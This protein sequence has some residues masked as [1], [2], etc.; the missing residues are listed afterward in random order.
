[1]Q[2]YFYLLCDSEKNRVVLLQ[3]LLITLVSNLLYI[4]KTGELGKRHV[5][6]LI[7]MHCNP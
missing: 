3:C 4:A 6:Y 1:M 2:N 5:K 7:I